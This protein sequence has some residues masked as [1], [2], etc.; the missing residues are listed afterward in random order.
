M[1]TSFTKASPL[2][3]ELF[4]LSRSPGLSI[5]VLHQGQP[6][7]TAHYGRRRISGHT[8]PNDDT[9]YNVASLTKLMAA[10]VVANLVAEGLLGWKVPI[11]Q[12]LPEFAERKDDIGLHATVTDLLANRTGLS[13]QNTF[14][15][16]MYEEIF[17]D[18]HRIPQLASHIPAIGEFRKKLCLF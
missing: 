2:I 3:Q 1:D 10:G 14:W 8:P 5:G 9:L 17:Q 4:E 13:A 12:Y 18:P 7:H 6:V 16:T 15:G 11:R